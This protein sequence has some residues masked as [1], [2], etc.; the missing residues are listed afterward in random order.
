[1]AELKPWPYG[2]MRNAAD[3][4]YG[5]V[6]YV[7]QRTEDGYYG[8][9][10]RDKR[11]VAAMIGPCKSITMCNAHLLKAAPPGMFNG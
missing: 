7:V 4:L 5:S 10:F 9:A 1:M 2:P 8:F 3:E 6:R 11:E